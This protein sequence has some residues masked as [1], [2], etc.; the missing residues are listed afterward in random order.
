MAVPLLADWDDGGNIIAS[1]V[2]A[3][4][5]HSVKMAYLTS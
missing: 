4:K 3:H 5:P 1:N 2:L